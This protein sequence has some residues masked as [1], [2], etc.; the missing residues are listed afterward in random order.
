MTDARYGRQTSLPAFGAAGQARL[1]SSR[2]RVV[3]AGAGAAPGLL[4]LA[5]AGVGTLWIDDPGS[6][7]PADTGCWLYEEATV[8]GPRADA[9]AKALRERTSLVRIEVEPEGADPT[10][11]ILLTGSAV[12]A[13]A[14]ADRARAARLPLVAAQGD[15]E[16]GTVVTVPPGAP[17]FACARPVGGAVRAPSPT[18][19]ALGALAAAELIFLLVDPNGAKGRRIDLVRGV[20]SMRPTARLAGCICGGASVG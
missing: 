3:G 8:G 5:L 9:A 12:T 14:A 13:L 10:A 2:V 6:I 19:G 18:A 7:A 4:Y 11:V 15:G 17:C 1:A 16:G 20:P